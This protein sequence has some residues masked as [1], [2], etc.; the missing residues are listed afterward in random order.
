[1]NFFPFYAIHIY[2]RK[3]KFKDSPR[4]ASKSF[5]RLQ[6]RPPDAS[7][8]RHRMHAVVPLEKLGHSGFR[9]LRAHR[10]ILRVYSAALHMLLNNSC[11]AYG[12]SAVYTLTRRVYYKPPANFTMYIYLCVH[13][14]RA[15]R[16]QSA[17]NSL[18][19]RLP[20]PPCG[21]LKCLQYL[22][23]TCCA[24]SVFLRKSAAAVV[25][26]RALTGV[27]TA[28]VLLPGVRGLNALSLT[29]SS[30]FIYTV[31][32][33]PLRRLAVSYPGSLDPRGLQAAAR[34]VYSTYS[35]L[36][37]FRDISMIV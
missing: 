18:S 37:I 10:V 9:A 21:I 6:R 7:N 22:Y 5:D 25:T 27:I 32:E 13:E 3:K 34:F 1:M 35:R 15:L 33:L 8:I 14:S 19:L 26:T 36:W 31:C 30:F 24:D 4:A 11:A 17:K 28:G 16:R 29:Y 12:K 23:Y 20:P 2:R